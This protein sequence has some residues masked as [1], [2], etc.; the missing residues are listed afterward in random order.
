MAL[1]LDFYEVLEI[2]YDSTYKEIKKAFHKKIREVHP[3][4]AKSLNFLNSSNKSS[5]EI[6]TEKDNSELH[7]VYEAWK[8]LGDTEKR[9][10]YDQKC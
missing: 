6:L 9:K 5:E 2:S 8:V 3:D 10:E 4:K 7:L 1:K